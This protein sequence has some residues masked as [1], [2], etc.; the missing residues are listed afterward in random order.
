MTAEDK[1]SLGNSEN[2]REPIQMQL[3]KNLKTFRQHFA[4]YVQSASNFRHF[5]KMR[6]LTEYVFSNL[7]TV[8]GTITQMFR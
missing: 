1:Y 4:Q 5:E 8:K 6:S 3:P 2:L 7:Q